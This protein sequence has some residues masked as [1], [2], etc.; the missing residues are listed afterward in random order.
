MKAGDSF[1]VPPDANKP[2]IVTG[3]PQVLNVTVGGKAVPPLG[4]ADKTIADVEVSAAALLA[5]PAATAPRQPLPHP[6]AAAVKSGN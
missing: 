5:R 2:M 6:H 3:R 1:T 4:V